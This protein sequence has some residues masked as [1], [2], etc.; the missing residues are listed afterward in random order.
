L[1]ATFSVAACAVPMA[2]VPSKPNHNARFISVSFYCM[3]IQNDR[4]NSLP[5]L[6][7]DEGVGRAR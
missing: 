1:M 4:L 5:A 3:R 2:K 6:T 7:G